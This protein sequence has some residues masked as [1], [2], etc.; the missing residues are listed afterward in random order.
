M[1]RL[2]RNFHLVATWRSPDNAIRKKTRNTT[3]LK[4]CAWNDTPQNTSECREVPLLPHETKQRYM[5]KPPKVTPFAE[6][7]IGTAIWGSRW[8]LRT[9]ADGWATSSE[10]TLNPQTP[11]VKRE[12]LLRIREKAAFYFK[13]NTFSCKCSALVNV[14]TGWCSPCL[15]HGGTTGG[16]HAS[17]MAC[18]GERSEIVGIWVSSD[19]WRKLTCM[20]C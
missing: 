11:R 12:P 14:F 10:H 5:L 13:K 9:V 19:E 15:G 3:R 6:L 8:R 2:P 16:W 1:P 7:T 4:R 18:H 17:A 20:V